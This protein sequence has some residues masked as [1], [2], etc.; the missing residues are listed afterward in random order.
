MSRGKVYRDVTIAVSEVL[1]GKPNINDETVRFRIG[2]GTGIH[3]M[4]GRVYTEYISTNIEFPVGDEMIL[5]IRKRTWG[6]GWP[7]YDGLYPM[8]YPLPPRIEQVKADEQTYQVAKF[9][10]AFFEEKYSMNIPV[11]TAFRFI[12]A[13]VKAPD[14]VSLLEEKIRPIQAI[15]MERLRAPNPIESP[16]FLAML[17]EELTKIE[18]L[19]K[20]GEAQGKGGSR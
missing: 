8:M 15:N 2:G 4:T 1:K 3:P 16:K 13:A 11:E 20:E 6:D 14:E 9:R 19:I 10:L 5:F 12:K 7:F 18:S 17:R